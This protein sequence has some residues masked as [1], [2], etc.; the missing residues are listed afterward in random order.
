VLKISKSVLIGPELER[1]AQDAIHAVLASVA[2]D[3]VEIQVQPRNADWDFEVRVKTKL[4]PVALLCDVKSRAWPNELHAI[5]YRLQRAVRTRQPEV[6]VPVLVAPY[7]S[8]QAMESCSELG[9]SWADLSGNADLKMEGVYVRVRGFETPKRETRS[10]TTLYGPRSSR[11]IHALLL[12]PSR[13]W[14]TESLASA[15]GVSFGQVSTVRNLLE[16]NDWLI[17]SYGVATLSEPKKLLED[18]AA[19]HK[20]RRIAHRY[21]SLDPP[22][23]LEARLESV[24]PDYALTE[25]A[26]ADRYAPYTRYQR[27][28]FYVPQWTEDHGR[29]LGLRGGDGASN[30]TIYETGDDIPFVEIVR[31]SRCVSPIQTY[32]DLTQL[33]GRGLAAAE[34][35]LETQIVG[36]WK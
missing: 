5:A 6:C 25:F 21:F 18:W 15:S 17:S 9:L 8:A 31:G 32:L 29:E 11:V 4:G 34:Y 2:I 10:A 7:F 14:N 19:H 3:E 23:K 27:V 28:A 12:E 33:A 16:Q 30:V 13:K 22:A 26:A 20:P 36:R 1:K 35:L 24:L